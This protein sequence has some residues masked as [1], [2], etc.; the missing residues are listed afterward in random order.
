M[1]PLKCIC[2]LL[3]GPNQCLPYGSS[4]DSRP[5]WNRRF[6]RVWHSL[7]YWTH[8]LFSLKAACSPLSSFHN[9]PE[10]HSRLKTAMW[11]KFLWTEISVSWKER[12]ID[13]PAFKLKHW[14]VAIAMRN[15]KHVLFTGNPLCISISTNVPLSS[16]G[17]LDVRPRFKTQVR[18]LQRNEMWENISSVTPSQQISYKI[19]C[20]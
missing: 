7:E 13:L 10:N 18:H 12:I 2:I 19:S 20:E 8:L 15:A 17:L 6:R 11:Q 1:L 3:R 5:S 4:S 14:S 16:L 9:M